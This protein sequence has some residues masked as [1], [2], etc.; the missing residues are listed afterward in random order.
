MNSAAKFLAALAQDGILNEESVS[1]A[2]LDR[3]YGP[4]REQVAQ[5]LKRQETV[6]QETQVRSVKVVERTF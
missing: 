4:I 2:Q 1:V 6:I 3:I 5:N